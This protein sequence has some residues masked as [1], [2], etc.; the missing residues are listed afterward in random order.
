MPEKNVLFYLDT[1]LEAIESIENYTLDSTFDE[2]LQDKKTEDA[3]VR[4]LEIIGE[5]MK[6]I[7]ED[8]RE[9][10]PE[11]NWKGFAGM[12]DKLIHHY[13]GVDWKI[14]WKT[15]QTLLPSLKSQILHIIEDNTG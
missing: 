15:I 2:F 13:F 9:N 10:N 11:V 6:N 3:V 14:V 5:A 7:P 1:I 8:F 12:R 4:N